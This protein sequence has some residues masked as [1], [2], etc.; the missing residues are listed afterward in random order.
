[1]REHFAM[2]II[3]FET[4]HLD[5]MNYTTQILSLFIIIVIIIIIMSMQS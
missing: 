1:M 5:M 2:Y 3:I 4:S